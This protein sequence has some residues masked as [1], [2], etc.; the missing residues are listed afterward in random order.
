VRGGAV[1][2]AGDHS[3]QEAEPGRGRVARQHGTG[4]AVP[5]T[6]G[7]GHSARHL[8]PF[9]TVNPIQMNLNSN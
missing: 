4:E 8:N 5:L 2:G 7:L 3:A 6:C 9:K 1:A